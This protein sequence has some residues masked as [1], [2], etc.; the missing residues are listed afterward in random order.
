MAEKMD[1]EGEVHEESRK[2]REKGREER[3]EGDNLWSKEGVRNEWGSGGGWRRA[4]RKG[5]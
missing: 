4:G 3:R 5:M 2:G 1:G